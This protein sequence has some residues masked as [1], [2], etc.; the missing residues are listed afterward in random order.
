MTKKRHTFVRMLQN[1]LKRHGK[2][3]SWIFLTRSMT[4]LK[5]KS[6]TRGADWSLTSHFAWILLSDEHLRK[7]L[8][9]KMSSD[10]IHGSIKRLLIE[11]ILIWAKCLPKVFI[12]CK[13]LNFKSFSYFF[14]FFFFY[15]E[16][17][18]LGKMFARSFHFWIWKV[19]CIFFLNEENPHCLRTP[20]AILQWERTLL[21]YQMSR[22]SDYSFFLIERLLIWA[23]CLP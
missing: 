11:G 10:T 18:D 9:L 16:I 2:I 7:L 17:I 8:T 13:I 20:G 14:K 23:K 6:L 22:E 19:P 4:S 21:T 12:V 15:R 1:V 3:Y 5:W